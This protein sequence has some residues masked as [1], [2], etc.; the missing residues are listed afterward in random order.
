[1]TSRAKLWTWS[2]INVWI[3]NFFVFLVFYLLFVTMP[4]YVME[5]I[6][7]GEG[8]AGLVITIFLLAAILIRPLT[9]H[10]VE[11]IGRMP[12]L[13]IALSI[14]GISSLLYVTTD[15]LVMI[16]LIRFLHGIGFGMAST[17]LGA[18]AADVVPRQRKGEGMGYFAMSMNFAMVVGPF[19]GL[20]LIQSFSY[21]VMFISCIT[22]AVIAFLTGVTIK[23]PK[24][25]RL[26]Q[27]ERESVIPKLDG[28]FEKSVIPIAITGAI[29]ALAY[30]GVLSFVSV[31]AKGLGLEEASSYF[32]VV[33]AVV[34]L[35]SRPFTGRWFDR[36]GENVIV[37]PSIITFGVGLIVLSLA[38]NSV[39]LL[40]AGGLIGLGWGT[41]VPS[42]QTIA[43]QKVPERAGSATATF[44]TIFDT[45][46]GFGSYVVGAAASGIGLSSLYFQSS[47]FVFAAVFLYIWL[48]GRKMKS[49]VQSKMEY[50]S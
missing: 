7:A 46:V 37:I 4:V 23:A 27:G 29:V 41:M 13:I 45:G 35:I 38:D 1:M 48:H 33:Y 40:I 17:V 10:W 28:L 24:A 11:T 44:F 49:S 43:L 34:L 14:F 25:Q 30:A 42:M 19:L 6:Q 47:F 2:F 18:L 12:I 8:A 36:Y 15:S 3:S 9:G 32:F 5:D 39:M 50:S 16:L 26:S 21:P 22:A 31:Y 20:T